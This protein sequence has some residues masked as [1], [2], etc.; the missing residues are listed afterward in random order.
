MGIGNFTSF[1]NRPYLMPDDDLSKIKGIQG[2]VTESRSLAEGDYFLIHC[3]KILYS[4]GTIIYPDNM[5]IQIS[6][7]G[8]SATEG[9][10]LLFP[11]NFKKVSDNLRNSRNGYARRMSDRGI[12]YCSFVPSDKIRRIGK[13]ND[14]KTFSSGIRDNLVIK[15]EK[16][17]LDRKCKAF[18]VALIL[19]DKSLIS[20]E[21]RINFS[22][23][24]IAHILALSGTHLTLIMGFIL[25]LLY[26]LNYFGL[27]KF[28]YW[29][30]VLILW[31]YTLLTGCSPSSVRAA[32]MITF[33]VISLS[34]QRRN[35]SVNALLASVFIILLINPHSLYEIGLQLSFLCV[36]CVLIFSNRLNT[37]D[38]H[39]HPRLYYLNNS[40]IVSLVATFGTWALVSYY[41]GIIPLLFLPA[42]LLILPI[43]PIYMGIAFVYVISLAMGCEVGILV[44]LLNKG[45]CLL[46]SITSFVS[47]VEGSV[48]FFRVSHIVVWLWLGGITVL[49]TLMAQK[50]NIITIGYCLCGLLGVIAFAPVLSYPDDVSMVFPAYRSENLIYF[51]SGQEEKRM[52]L[53]QNK[54]GCW[55]YK[56]KYVVSIDSAISNRDLDQLLPK[57]VGKDD[58]AWLM[59]CDGYRLDSIC[60]IPQRNLFDKI[61][62]HPSVNKRIE[63]NLLRQAKEARLQNIHSLREDGDIEF[64][65]L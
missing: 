54:I 28:R 26:P 58:V 63:K 53:P 35:N 45:Y 4:S 65:L 40:V 5:Y 1:I 2:K 51:Y 43:L 62:I 46:D 30:G 64:V 12:L 17:S 52:T 6:T 24:G 11:V 19:G 42:N 22:N 48:I 55:K 33:V 25:I 21:A 15:I 31:S 36:F 57:I 20:P 9:D 47:S 44:F 32:I 13:D 3:S 10:R 14:L 16:S 37:V 60:H 39:L 27:R 41:F 38:R 50:R 49:V 61:I 23:S 18:L 8:F 59:I 7:D 29:L 34:V 56:N